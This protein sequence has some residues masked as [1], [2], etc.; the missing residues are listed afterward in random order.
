MSGWLWSKGFPLASISEEQQ[1]VS[2][3]NRA[4]KKDFTILMELSVSRMD[5]P[6]VIGGRELIGR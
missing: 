5:S 3:G 4:Q 2:R 1:C 6:E